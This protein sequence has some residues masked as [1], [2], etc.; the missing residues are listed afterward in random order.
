MDL[1]SLTQIKNYYQNIPTPVLLCDKKFQILW[2]NKEAQNIYPMTPNDLLLYLSIRQKND[3][4]LSLEEHYQCKSTIVYDAYTFVLCFRRGN[5]DV[6]FI[7]IEKNEVSRYLYMEKQ[8]ELFLSSFSNNIRNWLANIF[9]LLPSVKTALEMHEEYNRAKLL[10]VIEE[11]S[12]H[13]L[14]YIVTYLDYDK[15]TTKKQEIYQPVNVFESLH[16]V[17]AIIEAKM[18]LQGNQFVYKIK[19]K[20]AYCLVD[21]DEFEIAVLHLIANAFKFNSPGNEVRLEAF[22]KNQKA[23]IQVSDK[24]TGISSEYLDR[25]FEPLYSFDPNRKMP[26]GAGLGLSYVQAF[27]DKYHGYRMISSV[28]NQGTRFIMSLPVTEKEH[29]YIL[30]D[31]TETLRRSGKFSPINVYLSDVLLHSVD[32]SYEI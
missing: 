6:F 9:N 18:A 3:I 29:Q 28:E 19:E 11:N 21:I 17:C 7:E 32:G 24:G 27:L 12:M 16:E 23:V 5:K 14:K 2:Y 1:R 8:E 30:H 10:D 22:V 15:L 13:I 25:I 4:L 31:K 20:V 26:F